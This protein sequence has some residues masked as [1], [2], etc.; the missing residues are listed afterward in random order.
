MTGRRTSARVGWPSSWSSYV[1]CRIG[2]AS[3][4][5]GAP[6]SIGV[7]VTTTSHVG[8]VDRLPRARELLVGVA[9]RRQDRSDMRVCS[10]LGDRADGVRARVDELAPPRPSR[11]DLPAPNGIPPCVMRRAVLDDEHARPSS[12]GPV[13]SARATPRE[14]SCARVDAPRCSAI[15]RSTCSGVAESTLFTTTTS[16]RRRFVSPGWYRTRGPASAGRRRRRA[17]RA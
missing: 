17:G 11:R 8:G 12:G 15:T 16:A 9:H 10:R 6:R 1:A 4:G 14:R 2:M 13:A 3:A 5:S 7:P